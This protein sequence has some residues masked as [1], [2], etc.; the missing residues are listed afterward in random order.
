[1][2]DGAHGE[3]LQSSPDAYEY[4]Q[5]LETF[6]IFFVV[7]ESTDHCPLSTRSYVNNAS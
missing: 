2:K 6:E 3:Q 4:Y 5:T 7:R 1:M